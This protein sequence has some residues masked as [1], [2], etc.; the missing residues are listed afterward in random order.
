MKVAAVN[1][2]ANVG[3]TTMDEKKSATAMMIISSRGR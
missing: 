3:V 2:P 1:K